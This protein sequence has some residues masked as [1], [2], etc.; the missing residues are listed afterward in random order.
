MKRILVLCLALLCVFT[1]CKKEK[2]TFLLDEDGYGCTNAQ[3]GV[4][5]TALDFCYQPAKTGEEV[6][7]YIRDEVEF[8]RTYYAI[9]EQDTALF[10]AD[11]E[12]S[13]WYAG[14]A[15]LNPLEMTAEQILVCENEAVSM[16]LFSFTAKEEG[17]TVKALVDLW[18]EGAAVQ[19]PDGTITLLRGVRL[20]F[21]ELKNIHYCVNFCVIEGNG[22]LYDVGSGRAVAVPAD[23]VAKLSG[24]N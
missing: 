1:A 20:V 22:Y 8:T 16:A 4:H 9:P 6:G 7:A 12:G 18:F 15:P 23:L 24:T 14:S 3:T 10:L 5:Y 11:D 2:S 21:A 19:K 13:V 17:A